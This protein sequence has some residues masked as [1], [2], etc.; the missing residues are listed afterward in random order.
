MAMMTV[1]MDLMN[2]Q[3]TAS[4]RAGHA[5]VI[6]S[7]VIMETVFLVSISVMAITIASTTRMKMRDISAVSNIF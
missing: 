6:C 5:S 3:S 4:Q 2:L 7:H 1:G